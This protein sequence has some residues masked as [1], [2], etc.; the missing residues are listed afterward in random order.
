[1]DKGDLSAHEA[2]HQDFLEIADG[3]GDLE[4]LVATGMRPPAAP[5]RTTRD[6]C[7]DGRNRPGG[8][9]E[10]DAVLANERGCLPIQYAWYRSRGRLSAEHVS[11]MPLLG[12]CSRRAANRR[13]LD[14]ALSLMSDSDRS[15][16]TSP[17]LQIALNRLPNF[18]LARVFGDVERDEPTFGEP[19]ISDDRA[20]G[21]VVEVKERTRFIFKRGGSLFT[22][23]AELAKFA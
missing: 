22:Q 17:A 7:R 23:L 8:R 3:L 1:M 19:D 15:S 16:G 11:F 12:G 5:N 6:S 13:R 18:L 20:F 10:D 21:A 9:L 4:Y 2:T 14:V